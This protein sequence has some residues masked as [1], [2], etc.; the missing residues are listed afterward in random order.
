MSEFLYKK[1]SEKEKEEIN[2]EA[3]RIMDSF[4]KKL[5]SINN[6]P[7]EVDVIR[8]SGMREENI[9]EKYDS[10]F[11]KKI[12]DNAPKKNKHFILAEKKKW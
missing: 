6:L 4:G 8:G 5:G 1:L 2:L 3:K 9:E 12:L 11:K 10:K 7:K